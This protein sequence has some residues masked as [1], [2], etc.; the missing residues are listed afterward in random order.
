MNVKYLIIRRL[1]IAAIIL[2]SPFMV[3]AQSQ[4][5]NEKIEKII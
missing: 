1:I 3:R 4:T 5:E 2:I